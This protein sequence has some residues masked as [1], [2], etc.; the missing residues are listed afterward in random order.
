M[1]SATLADSRLS[2][3]ASRATANAGPRYWDRSPSSTDGSESF[4]IAEGSAPMVAT[5]QPVI[6]GTRVAM[7]TAS[8]EAG[9]ARWILGATTITATTIATSAMAANDPVPTELP[10]AFAAMTAVFSPPGLGTPSAAGTCWRKMIAAMPRVNPSITGHG[11]Y[12]STR[13]TRNSPAA[14]TSTPAI[15]P[16]RITELAPKRATR[17]TS[18]TVIA[19]V[20]PETCGSEPPNPPAPSPATIAVGGPAAAPSPVVI[21]KANANGSATPPTVNPASTSVRH[22]RDKPE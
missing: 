9:N 10:T 2:M 11:T 21:P 13:P 18:T 7:I 15:T 6:I 5:F 22:D 14:T 4:G 19:P 16:T 1:P 20:G 12:A 8:N 3:A 17:G